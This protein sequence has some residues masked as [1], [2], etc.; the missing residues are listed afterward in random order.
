MP[1]RPAQP[2]KT[3]GCRGTARPGR[4]TCSGCNTRTR[5]DLRIRRGHSTEQGYGR[6]HRDRFRTGVLTRDRVCV[7]CRRREAVVADHYPLDRKTLVKMR[8][9]PDDP[10]HGRGLCKRCHDQHSADAQPG[11]WYRGSPW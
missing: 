6:G 9:D 8:L 7:V 1:S 11:G 4:S 5:R 10:D 3:P 2:C